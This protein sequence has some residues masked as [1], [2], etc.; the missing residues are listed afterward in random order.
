MLV[1]IREITPKM[2]VYDMAWMTEKIDEFKVLLYVVKEDGSIQFSKHKGLILAFYLSTFFLIFLHFANIPADIITEIQGLPIGEKPEIPSSSRLGLA[3]LLYL[4]ITTIAIITLFTNG[5][6]PNFIKK[7]KMPSLRNRYKFLLLIGILFFSSFIIAVVFISIFFSGI[8]IIIIGPI[9]YIIWIILEPYFLLSGIQAIIR[10]IDTDYDLQGFS[11]RGKRVLLLCFILGYLS[12]FLFL[13]FLSVTSIGAGFS[14]LTILGNVFT[15]YQPALTSFNQ[16]ITSVLSITLFFL[17]LWWIKDKI[18]RNNAKREKKKGML[19]WFLGLTLILIIITVVPLIATTKGSLQE[20]TSILDI[21]GLFA[22]VIMGL[23]NALGIEQVR[24]PMKGIERINPLEYI[25]RLHPYTKSLFLLI[26]SIFAFFSSVESSTISALTGHPDTIKL[27]QL[28]LLAAFIGIAY[29]VIISR[30]QGQPRSTT[31]GL[32]ATTRSQF[33]EGVSI[34]KTIIEDKEIPKW[35]NFSI[36]K[37]KF[38][39][40]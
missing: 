16:T 33:E 34:V 38:E 12:P 25:S 23:W 22:A 13:I 18:W 4:Y 37:G 32:L 17:I 27:Q 36:Q 30:Y 40:E 2:D 1:G 8:I 28:E 39:Q 5:S 31:P 19:P 11:R 26:I 10:I 14:Q 35:G 21:L 3:I 7:P 29:F 9:L 24:K 15:F 6:V 20:L